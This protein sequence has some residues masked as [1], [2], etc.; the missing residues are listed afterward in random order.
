[1]KVTRLMMTMVILGS[2]VSMGCAGG[3]TTTNPREVYQPTW[4]GAT[5]NAEYLFVYG[6][7]ERTSQQA[8]ESSVYAS[9]LA[10]AANSV[11]TSVAT[12]MKDFISETGIDNPEVLSLTER[13]TRTVANQRFSGTQITQ[14]QTVTVEGGRYKAFVQ[15][16][17]PKSE[18]NRDLKNRIKN[19]EALY[20]RFRASQAFQE[21]DRATG[22]SE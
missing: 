6:N 13:V 1:M 10:E 12:M 8:A 15:V 16:A 4:Y 20:T 14:R 7:A 17:L 18:I 19:E 3:R 21:L 9:A 11:E 2:L 5:G 22:D